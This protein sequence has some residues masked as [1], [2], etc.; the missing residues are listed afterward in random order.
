M[1]LKPLR[2]RS[3]QGLREIKPYLDQ[4]NDEVE[5]PEYIIDD[6]VQFVHAF[7]EKKDQEIAGF[8]A[9]TMAWGRRD[10]VI[11]KVEDLLKRMDFNPYQF[12]MSYE[13]GE[14]SRLKSFKHRTFK[15]IDIHG[16]LLALK[17]IYTNHEDFE[18]FWRLCY[19]QSRKKSRPLMALFHQN[20]FAGCDDLANR[21]RKHISNPEK[22]STCKRLYMYL[23]WMIRKE[24]PVDAGIWNFIDTSE[25]L[26]PFDVHVARQARKYGLV[27]RKSNDFKT[28]KQLTQTLKILNPSDPVRYDYALFG[29]GA[30]GYTLPTKFILNKV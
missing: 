1:A 20:F 16:I 9:A 27:A 23:R 21:T 22:G 19:D 2:Q 4:I 13:Q 6:P 8:L 30:L 7:N 3:P 28:V 18:S 5:K 11:S 10:I 25:L 26:I 12:V 14:F 29:M 24:S 17:Q 15:P